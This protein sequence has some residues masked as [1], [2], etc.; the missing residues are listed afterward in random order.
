M[1]VGLQLQAQ[2]NVNWASPGATWIY[3]NWSNMDIQYYLKM[4]YTK[5]TVVHNQAVKKIE[6]T[7]LSLLI[8]PPPNPI[9]EPVSSY[10]GVEYMYESNDTVYRFNPLNNG[11][12][13]VLYI[14]NPNLGD[15]FG[16]SKR[17]DITHVCDTSITFDNFEVDSVFS[18]TH[19]GQI[20]NAYR[21]KSNLSSW[22]FRGGLSDGDENSS[23]ILEN[24]G[25]YG[26]P[27]PLPILSDSCSMVGNT[28]D[29]PLQLIC[30]KDAINGWA[31]LPFGSGDF[32]FC[33]DLISSSSKIVKQEEEY[34]NIKVY[35]NP[36][37]E[38]INI[39]WT[40]F[41]KYANNNIY[42]QVFDVTGKLIQTK[43]ITQEQ[44]V[45]NVHG[46][47]AGVYF[48]K[49]VVENTVSTNFKFVK[50]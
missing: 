16:I 13:K 47:Q 50:I 26:S 35:P 31:N 7:K 5:D 29:Y 17:E 9:G 46:L 25:S 32:T 1:I 19:A 49:I 33:E 40:D 44:V 3:G 8:P 39:E 18:V 22:T 36:V 11:G 41:Y 12:F 15:V 23:F 14:F 45:I 28:A 2:Q 43:N 34:V 20:W 38:V 48:L 6:L 21:T 10:Y 27:F 30:Y 4:T 37:T 24:I 42:L